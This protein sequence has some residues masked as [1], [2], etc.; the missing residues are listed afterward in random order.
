MRA[1]VSDGYGNTKPGAVEKSLRRISCRHLCRARVNNSDR[2]R[3]RKR[4]SYEEISF[5]RVERPRTGSRGTRTRMSGLSFRKHRLAVVLAY[6]SRFLASSH[7]C[8]EG[9][10]I[11]GF[12][13]VE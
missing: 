1:S 4:N 2:V 10:H 7:G 12:I 3:N 8:G 13:E 11:H 9:P 6:P 5:S